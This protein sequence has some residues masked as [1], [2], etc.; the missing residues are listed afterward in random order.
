M[1]FTFSAEADDAAALAATILKDHTKPE[2]LA[3]VEAA[4]NRFDPVLWSALGDA[5]L[6]SLT[7]PESHDGAGLGFVELCRVLVEVGRTVAPAPLAPDAVARL[8][9]GEHGSDEQQGTAFAADVLSCAIAEEHEYAPSVPTT[10]AAED[11]GGFVLTGT[12]YLVPAA[13]VATAF[14]IPATTPT[15]TAV[16]LV[17]A[18]TA[19][20]QVQEQHLSDGDVVGL[21]ELDGARVPVE[22]LVGGPD[23][24]AAQR[25]VDLLTVATCAVQLGVT[26]GAISLTAEYAKTREQFDRPI[27]T[28]QAVAQRLADG[29]IDTR[30][31]ALTVW[32]AAWRLAEGLPAEE[33][34]ATAKLWAADAGHRIAHTTVHIHGGVGIDLDG[35]A[36][37]YFTAAT[38]YESEHGGA[39]E[40][41]LRLGRLLAAEPA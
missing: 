3:E 36:H 30:F 11:D 32:Q 14:L 24:D 23:G 15:G 21:L 5:G 37:R 9:L 27:G 33:A 34:I 16:F 19:G 6:R 22:R 31:Q 35:V 26:E 10:T 2:R 4:G 17:D 29:Y 8:F 18:D 39:T 25:L 28:F 38:R 41:A 13:T 7:T 40:Q 1:D 20:L 12:K